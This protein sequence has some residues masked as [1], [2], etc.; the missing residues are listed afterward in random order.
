MSAECTPDL[1]AARTGSEARI[2]ALDALRGIAALLVLLFH[3][4]MRYDQL[5]VHR[6]PILISVPWGGMGVNLFFGIEP[7]PLVAL[8][9]PY[10]PNSTASITPFF[11]PVCLRGRLSLIVAHAD[12]AIEE[13]VERGERDYWVVFSVF[14]QG[15]FPNRT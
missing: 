5:F 14:H 4:T 12:A 8:Q 9:F 6:E 11:T 3:Y 1:P 10:L 2:P 15:C 7:Y 13:D